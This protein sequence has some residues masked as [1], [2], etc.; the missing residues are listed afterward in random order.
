MTHANTATRLDA[1]DSRDKE[2]W[3]V[4]CPSGLKCFRSSAFCFRSTSPSKAYAT[5]PF[6]HAMASRFGAQLIVLSVVPGESA[7]TDAAPLLKDLEP[8]MDGVFGKSL[9]T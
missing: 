5:A 9:R 2:Q 4:T 7:L 8:R 1:F 3:N 6:V